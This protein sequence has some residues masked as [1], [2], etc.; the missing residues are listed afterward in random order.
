M[1]FSKKQSVNSICNLD[2]SY[3]NMIATGSSDKT[4]KLWQI[5]PLEG[6]EEP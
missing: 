2:E 4:I 6:M 5:S 1:I 3:E